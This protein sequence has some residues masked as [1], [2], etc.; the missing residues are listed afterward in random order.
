M[1]QLIWA[2]TE[3]QLIGKNNRI[4]WHIKEDLLYYKN[5]T[6]GKT[7]LMGENTYYSLRDTIRIG[8]YPMGKFMWHPLIYLLNLRMQR[9]FLMQT[10]F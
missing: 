5:C 8:L 4:P 1:I 7:V 9:L 6:A 10:N 2:M 3:N